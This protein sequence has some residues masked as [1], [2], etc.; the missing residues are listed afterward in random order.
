MSDFAVSPS[1]SLRVVAV[2]KG[3]SGMP[4][5]VWSVLGGGHQTAGAVVVSD[6]REPE[7]GDVRA[8]CT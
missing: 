5:R 3:C 4:T 1:G 7:A 6:R 8:A 2:M